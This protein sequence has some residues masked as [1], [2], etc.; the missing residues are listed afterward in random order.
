[1][2]YLR[3]EPYEKIIPKIHKTNGEVI[4]E[5][6]VMTDDRAIFKHHNFLRLYRG[7]FDGLNGTYQG[8]KLYTCKTLEKILELRQTT[9]EYCGEWFDVYDKNGKVEIPNNNQEAI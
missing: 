4:P 1:M 2:Y 3:K 6:K 5:R 7:V 8:M 9:F